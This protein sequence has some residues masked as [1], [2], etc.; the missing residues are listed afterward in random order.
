V[1]QARSELERLEGELLEITNEVEEK[2]EE[3]SVIEEEQAE[4]QGADN[5]LR[6]IINQGNSRLSNQGVPSFAEATGTDLESLGA[7][8]RLLRQ[9]DYIF[10]RSFEVLPEL[11]RIRSSEGTFFLEDGQEVSGTI[12]H[13]GQ[14]GSFGVSDAA[15]G[16]LAPAGGGRLRLVRQETAPVAERLAGNG[17][18]TVSSLP[19]YLYEDTDELA[20]VSE[21]QG[22]IETIEGGGVIGLVILVIGGVSVLLI[23]LRSIFLSRVGRTDSKLIEE[24][25]TAVKKGNLG[26]ALASAKKVPGAMGRVLTATIHGLQVDPENI[27]DVIS[28]SVL[29]EQPALDRFRSS[30]SVFAAVAPL[31]GLLGTVTGMISTFDVIT[32]YGTGD[33]QLLSGG[34]S[35]ALITTELGLA[36]AIPTLLI[37]NLLASWGDRITSNLEVTALRAVN[38]SGGYEGAA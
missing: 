18:A 16:T 9:V 21:G 32:Q 7:E 37:G 12:V 26:N 15:A 35:E 31:L 2:N 27:E 20:E 14:V 33:P 34:I 29:N 8:E 11:A 10:D 19:M 13:I 17:S 24:T 28:E 4:S 3:L 6:T 36:V 5:T 30:L 22:L 25:F 1:E 38:I 23:I